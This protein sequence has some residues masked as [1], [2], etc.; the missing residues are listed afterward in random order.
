[1]KKKY[2]MVIDLRK[3]VGCGGCDLACKTENNTADGISWGSHYTE[4]TGV[5]P[6]VQ[7][8]HIPTLCNHCEDPPCVRVCPTQ[9]MYVD[10]DGFVLH[11][12]ESCIGCQSCVL[13]DPYGVIHYNSRKPT[14]KWE[15]TKELVAGCTSSGREIQRLT[16][17]ELPHVNP[18]RGK[19][20]QAVR[21]KGIVEKCTFCDHKT[22]QGQ[23]PHCV[24]SCPAGARVFGD[25]ND[26]N[27]EASRLLQKYKSRVLK[28]HKGTRPK[29]HY[30][31]NYGDNA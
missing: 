28:P 16:K 22:K 3:C 29:V 4:T 27:S 21:D 23:Q 2:G 11:S 31:R 12:A 8:E 30:I 5:F 1:M 13:A 25:L 26:S 7:Y 6:E 20:Y 10:E 18:D 14:A 24:T 17:Q 9:S 19:T 15:S